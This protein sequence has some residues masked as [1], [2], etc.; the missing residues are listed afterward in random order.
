[1][2]SK[3]S[4]FVVLRCG[5]ITVLQVLQLS[6]NVVYGTYFSCVR[7]PRFSTC[8]LAAKSLCK[9][10]LIKNITDGLQLAIRNNDMHCLENSMCLFK[11]VIS[12]L[13]LNAKPL[14]N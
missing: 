11:Q 5:L 13:V 12:A 9:Q 2:V 3:L 7:V 8:R 4:V 6:Q 10:T 14:C 1:M